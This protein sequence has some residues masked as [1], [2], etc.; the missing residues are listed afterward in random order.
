M[1]RHRPGSATARILPSHPRRWP[2]RRM[3]QLSRSHWARR[4]SERPRRRPQS[5]RLGG[6]QM[7]R[8]LGGPRWSQVRW[9]W[10]WA[11]LVDEN[12]ME[13]SPEV[14]GLGLLDVNWVHRL[15]E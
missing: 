10:S 15:D 9:P 14:M 1:D 12:E 3:D 11:L 4:S 13:D 6:E 2:R 5:R 7:D 8:S